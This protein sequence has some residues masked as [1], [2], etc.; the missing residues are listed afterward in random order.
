MGK[1][2]VKLDANGKIKSKKTHTLLKGTG[3]LNE[4]LRNLLESRRNTVMVQYWQ[5]CGSA[6]GR[7]DRVDSCK[8]I[9]LH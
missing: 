5:W 2:Y 4:K 8:W 7:I 6:G 3:E 1:Y 9:H